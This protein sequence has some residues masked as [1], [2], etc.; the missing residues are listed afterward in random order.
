MPTMGA[1]V[2][3]DGSACRKFC[4]VIGIRPSGDGAGDHIG[5]R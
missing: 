2:T 1:T 4:P 5:I 3:V